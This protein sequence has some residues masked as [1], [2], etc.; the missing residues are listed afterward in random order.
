M[1]YVY[2]VPIKQVRKNIQML[3]SNYRFHDL[4]FQIGYNKVEQ[5]M[6]KISDDKNNDHFFINWFG[7]QTSGE[8]SSVY[9]NLWGRLNLIPSYHIIID[10]LSNTQTR[11]KI[12]S[13]P[14]VEAGWEVSSNHL[15]PYITSRKV[16]VKP[17]SI[18]EYELIKMIGLAS[19]LKNMPQTIVK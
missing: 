9:Y 11:I 15:L 1:S 7:W 12:E 5:K 17:S 3:F 6:G 19:G 16:D 13:F 18:E 14:A 8:K 10:S 4:D 2:N